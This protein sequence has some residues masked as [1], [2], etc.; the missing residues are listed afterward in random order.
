MRHTAI[1]VIAALLGFGSWYFNEHYTIE[2]LSD[3]RVTPR[4]G[5]NDRS[6]T[7]ISAPP[8]ARTT[9][10]IRIAS[11]NLQVFGDRKLRK[12]AVMEVLAQIMRQFDVIAVQEI[13]SRNQDT[14]PLFVDMINTAGR[15][16]DYVIGPRLGRTSSR[17]Q[18]AFV[19]D[20]AS[21]EVDRAQLYT[22]ADPD[23][24]LHREPLVGWF[25][26]RGPSSDRAFT[27]SLVNIHIDP[28]E[29]Q[30]ELDALDDVFRVVRDDGRDEDDVIIAGDLNADDRHLGQL[31]QIPGITW[32][33]SSTPTNTRG[34]EQYDNILFH[35]RATS[36]F[37]GRGGT[38]D[39]MREFNMT[40][41][42]ALE[43][44]DHLPVWAEFSVYE[45]GAAGRVATR[46]A[47]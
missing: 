31:G 17:E 45:G 34:N 44:S 5:A 12:P 43:I 28:D 27:F 14:L 2:G 26:V 16:Y 22:V 8:P 3:I 36:E 41:D 40:V 35:E 20:R 21:V 25:R 9:E 19:F 11:F 47:R 6:G 4:R 32:I 13:R 30:A 18:Y 7:W 1:L 38:F 42:E 37:S 33:V 23:D 39:F 15:D 29:V 46:P 24:L 10:T